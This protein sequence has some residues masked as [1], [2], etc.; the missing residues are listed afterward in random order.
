MTSLKEFLTTSF[1][2]AFEAQ[3]LA[4]KFG[5]VVASQRP[6][7]SQFQCNGA[8]A[9]ANLQKTNPRDLARRIADAVEP[10]DA[11]AEVSLAGPGF[12]NISLSD[13]FLA[14][15]VQ[16]LADDARLGCAPA[17][18][19]QHILIDF[20]GPNVAKPM[21]VGH[22][23]SSIIGDCLQRLCRFMGHRV[24]SDIHLGDWGTP[25]GMLIHELQRR[26]PHLPYFD[27]ACAGPYPAEPPVT[28]SDL[29]EMYPSVVARCQEDQ[30][31]MEAALQ[32]T[33]ELQQGRAGYLALW[34]HFVAVSVK[35]LKADFVS[36]GVTFDLWRG[37]SDYHEHIPAMLEKLQANGHAQLSEGALVIPLAHVNGQKEMPPLILLKSD[38][39]FLYGTT[40]LATLFERVEDFRA[41]Q[42]LYVVDGRQSLHFKQLFQAAG[43][44][45]LTQGVKL[46]HLGFG[47]VNGLDGKP[48][49][50]RAGKVMRLKDLIALVITEAFK[51]LDETGLAKDYSETERSDVARKVGLAALKFA[52][53]MNHHTSDYSFDLEKFTRFEGRTGPYLLY[54]AVRIKSIL[55]LAQEKSL[56]S[57]PILPPTPAERALMLALCQL[58]DAV[59]NAY[60]NYAP[61]HLCD[62]AYSLGREFNRFYDQCH[63]LS[64][65]DPARQLS[66]LA[67]A[68]LCLA[69]LELLLSLLGIETPERM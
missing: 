14:A 1:A 39:G 54:T 53:L 38:G 65:A 36:L 12:I 55:R 45:G 46:E 47:T 9:A 51:R 21:H 23:R 33:V 22:L 66:W 10:R 64:E 11:F 41:D 52:D 58:P 15:Q 32:A 62:F 25:M 7:L 20:G 28:I 29:Q 57:G 50:T 5:E 18:E 19:P 59:Q 61:N 60:E 6:E 67:L 42:I 31:E 63:I 49:K 37:E 13:E 68:Q 24:I 69:E 17:T 30:G 16:Q 40:D 2:N 26:Q 44:I 56:L 35:E 8:L 4:R 43:Q 34:R 27:P 48:F 3:G